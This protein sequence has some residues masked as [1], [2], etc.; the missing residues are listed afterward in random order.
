MGCMELFEFRPVRLLA[1]VYALIFSL[2]IWAQTW[3]E[4]DR[5]LPPVGQVSADEALMEVNLDALQRDGASHWIEVR[6][7][8]LEPRHINGT[9]VH[10]VLAMAEVFCPTS[11]VRWKEPRF[12]TA[13]QGMGQEVR[14]E[15]R[16]TEAHKASD[17]L[18]LS[19]QAKLVRSA[20]GRLPFKGP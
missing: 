3:F 16:D 20:C 7:S 1:G 14:I 19:G 15:P 18:P 5:T 10:S 9:P 17:W 11:L 8:W 2:P 13:R 6:H 4:L 12:F